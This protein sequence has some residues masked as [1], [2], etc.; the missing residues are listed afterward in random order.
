MYSLVISNSR[1]LNEYKLGVMRKLRSFN[2]D[3]IPDD[4]TLASLKMRRMTI[5]KQMLGKMGRD[6]SIESPFFVIWGCNT[7]VGNGVYINRQ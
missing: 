6:T 5:A 7:F 4:A 2:D 3:N 1:E